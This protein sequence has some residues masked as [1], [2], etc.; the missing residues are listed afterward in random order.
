VENNIIFDEKNE[1]EKNMKKIL[2]EKNI[3]TYEGF[4]SNGERFLEQYDKKF[5]F[6]S[7]FYPGTGL[8]KRSGIIDADGYDCGQDSFQASWPTLVD[9]GIANRCPAAH[10]C[11]VDCYQKACESHGK[12][13]SL[14]DVEMILKQ[15]THKVTS[16]ALGG[17]GDIDCYVDDENTSDQSH[18][19]ERLLKLFRQY[20]IVPSFTTSG[21]AMTPEKA[22]ICK[23][24]TG[25]V[26]VS[27]HFADYTDRAI[28]ML[29]KAGVKTNLHYVLNKDTIDTAIDRIKNNSWKEGLNAIVFLMYKPIGL[30]KEEKILTTDNP[31]VKEFFAVLDEALEKNSLSVKIGFD[32]CSMSG[33]VNYMKNV[34]MASCDACEGGRYSCYITPELELLP[35]SFD[36][37]D[38]RWAVDLKTHTFEEAWNS[39]KFNHFRA[40]LRN[41][42]PGCPDRENCR[43]GCPIVN[44]ITLCDREEREFKQ[45]NDKEFYDKSEQIRRF[46]EKYKK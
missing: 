19:F 5:H 31:K 25:A 28:D 38:K 23:T 17:K 33:L 20:D 30:G 1:R 32:S 9:F 7:R 11:V 35:C 22:H 4:N 24:Y 27:E 13:V 45:P 2:D 36:N 41:S 6:K 10:T 14:A 29:L 3:V 39:D 42:C 12:N 15:I 40:S 44:Q 8:Y 37:Q 43:G 34:D 21:I 16:A 18:D 46:I 26:A